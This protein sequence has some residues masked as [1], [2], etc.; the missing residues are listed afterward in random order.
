MDKKRKGLRNISRV[1]ISILGLLIVSIFTVSS[2]SYA[3]NSLTEET[4]NWEVEL[5]I[6]G[7]NLDEVCTFG[8]HEESSDGFDLHDNPT[9]PLPPSNFLISYFSHP[10]E[11][12]YRRFKKDIKSIAGQIKTWDLEIATDL[13]NTS[14]E[15]TWGN[16]DQALPGGDILKLI[17]IENNTEIDMRQITN[18]AYTVGAGIMNTRQFRIEFSRN[19]TIPDIP[20]EPDSSAPPTLAIIPS[21]QVVLE[22]QT[23][24]ITVNCENLKEVIG[25][26]VA[27]NFDKELLKAIEIIPGN[28]PQQEI[29]TVIKKR[30][31]NDNGIIEYSLVTNPGTT[32]SCSGDIFS[33]VFEKKT[34]GTA[35]INFNFVP[36][37]KTAVVAED[38]T[39][40]IVTLPGA[41]IIRKIGGN[42]KGIVKF[43]FP[44]VTF[45]KGINVSVKDLKIKAT[46]DRGGNFMLLDVPPGTQTLIVNVPGASSGMWTDVV[47]NYDETIDVGSMTLLNADANDDKFVGMEDYPFYWRA[48]GTKKEDEKF[49]PRADWNGDGKVDVRDYGIF[50]A[51]F[52]KTAENFQPAP[53]LK[54]QPAPIKLEQNITTL[55]KLDPQEKNVNI[56]ETFDLNITLEKVSNMVAAQ[57]YITYDPEVLEIIKCEKGSLIRHQ[58]N[59]NVSL[60]DTK[61]NDMVGYVFEVKPGTPPFNGSG[62]LG[63]VSFRAKSPGAVDIGFNKEETIFTS[64]CD[65]IPFNSIGSKITISNFILTVEQVKVCLSPAKDGKIIFMGLPYHASVNIYNI[66]GEEIYR[67]E[68]IEDI[69]DNKWIWE[70]INSSGDKVASGVYIYVIKD[71]EGNKKIGKLGVIK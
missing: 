25:I 69:V 3:T 49:D 10:E 68:N 19:V 56:N 51:N 47:V 67:K 48:F 8:I 61:N 71:K 44:R 30:I 15:I 64:G 4:N 54:P 29:S 2:Q 38:K 66:A 33:V 22:G 39:I 52:G 53:S 27:L 14:V 60:I 18:Y 23:P 28:F 6:T 43:D 41:I 55:L 65:D 63:V 58:K 57:V 21:T 12:I 16:L 31:D 11:G 26:Q 37:Y 45:H 32:A 70:C 17:D 13:S 35:A 5:K 46:T 34:L 42:I 36:P 7:G 40:P 59:V 20:T 50:F 9:P 1:I 24:I 62:Q